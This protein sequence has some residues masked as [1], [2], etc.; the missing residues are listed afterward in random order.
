MS[1]SLGTN[2]VENEDVVPF[3]AWGWMVYAQGRQKVAGIAEL[4]ATDTL[5]VARA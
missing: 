2:G 1:A 4:S 5:H 3:S